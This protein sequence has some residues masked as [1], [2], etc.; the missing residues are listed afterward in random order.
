M[1]AKLRTGFTT[2]TCAAAAAKAAAVLLVSGVRIQEVETPLPG[3]QRVRLQV[4]WDERGRPYVIKDAGDDPDCTHGA[5]VTVELVPIHGDEVRFAAGEGVGTITKP[6]LGLAVGDPAI[7]PV[8]RRQIAEAIREVTPQGVLVT[9]SVPGGEEMA[10]RTTNARLGIV[11]GISILGTTGIVRPFSTAS[12]R[13]SVVQQLDVAA[14]QGF[15]RCVLAT[16]SRTEERALQEHP[17]LDPVC[18]VEVGD[19]TGIAV[20]RAAHHAMDPI[21]W[22][23]MVGKVTKVASGMLMTHFHRGDVDTNLL[24][25]LARAGGAS[26][27]VVA[28]AGETATARHFYE[29]CREA[30]E[31]AP[32]EALVELA[33]RRLAEAIGHRAR[34]EVVLC[35]VDDA[36]V[37]ARAWSRP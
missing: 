26:E 2:G 19:F 22:Y 37:V 12:Y 3:G 9:V 10:A 30:G 33:A 6:G 29:A 1:A 7:N 20:R 17:E 15:R 36:S 35:D 11:G 27:R 31:Y 18:I 25:Q 16:G 34:I 24:E 28:A 4:S 13:A 5:H 14:A 8:P 32:L 23:A 21:S